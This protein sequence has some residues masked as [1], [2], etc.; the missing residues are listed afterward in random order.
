MAKT[1]KRRVPNSSYY[2]PN[3]LTMVSFHTPF[4]NQLDPNNRLARSQNISAKG[5]KKLQKYSPIKFNVT[6]KTENG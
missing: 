3:Q 2:S 4:Y 5:Q 6:G 1:T